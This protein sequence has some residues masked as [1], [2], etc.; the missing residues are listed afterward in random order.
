[1]PHV[2]QQRDLHHG[3]HG[4]QRPHHPRQKGPSQRERDRARSAAH[5]AQQQNLLKS[6]S[7]AATAVT[8]PDESVD[9]PQQQNQ[10]LAPAASA[11]PQTSPPAD[12]AGHSPLA[13]PHPPQLQAAAA[14]DPN[15]TSNIAATADPA[16][17]EPQHQVATLSI[18]RDEFVEEDI[19][20]KVFATGVFENCPDGNLSEDYFVSLRKFILSENHLQQNISS[21]KIAQLSSTQLGE[22]L[23]VHTVKVEICVKIARLWEPPLDYIR[24][25]L[26]KNDWLKSNKT[27]ITLANIHI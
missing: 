1:M 11:C 12:T 7:P 14:A 15:I 17:G 23:F 9:P 8:D 20:V 6:D 27:K 16:V 22:Q 13:P 18:V 5:R 24:K 25:H 21:I 3:V 26:A 4:L 19:E 10:I 2:P